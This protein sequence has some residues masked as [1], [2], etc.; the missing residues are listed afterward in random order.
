MT[1]D[2]IAIRIPAQAGFR[3]FNHQI[4]LDRMLQPAYYSNQIREHTSK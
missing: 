1:R 4:F 3:K 2:L